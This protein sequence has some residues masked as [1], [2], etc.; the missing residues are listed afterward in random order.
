MLTGTYVLL[1]I[2]LTSAATW[3][4]GVAWGVG[5]ATLTAGIPSVDILR[6]VRG[7]TVDDFFIVIRSQRLRPLIVALSCTG[8][9]F[10]LSL[11]L[12]AP[13]QLQASL[14]AALATGAVL[15]SITWAWKISF[16]ASAVAG[17]L[18]ILTWGVGWEML[19]LAPLVPAVAWSRV[20]L[21]RHTLA[22]VLAGIAVGSTL[23]IIVLSLY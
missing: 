3:T 16:H 10:A 19:V 5:L 8:L 20:A 12:G 21:G 23:T 9:A 7:R 15:T 4:A 17:A 13:Q 18:A 22:Q 14:L 1:I 11:V 6:R 2:A